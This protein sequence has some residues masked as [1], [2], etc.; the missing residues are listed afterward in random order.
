MPAVRSQLLDIIK[1]EKISY[2][3]CGTEWDVVRK[4]ICSAYLHQSAR[5]R[6][7]G[8]YVNLRTGMPCHLHPT[9]A[10]YGMGFTPD[11]VVFQELVMTSKERIQCV[12]SVDSHWLAEMGPMFFSAKEAGFN[13]LTK[14]KFE[15]T[16][17][18]HM[19]EEE[20]WQAAEVRRQ[21]EEEER[22]LSIESGSNTWVDWLTKKG[23]SLYTRRRSRP[24]TT[25]G[26]TLRPNSSRTGRS[27]RN[28]SPRL[29]RRDKSR[30]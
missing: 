24:L 1:S 4:C 11:Y 10:L 19:K 18:Q 3:T 28:I 23:N 16:S 13:R 5:L 8:E 22:A 2:Q 9:S 12:T 27:A 15:R 25:P 30:T 6:G 29:P 21:E 14:H 26:L 7:I 20:F 17:E